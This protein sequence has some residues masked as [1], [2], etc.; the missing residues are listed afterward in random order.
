[1]SEGRVSGVNCI[2]WTPT[3]SDR[4]ERRRERRLPDARDVLDQE[5]A[6]GEEA[7]D[8][9]LHGRGRPAVGRPDG[10]DEAGDGARGRRGRVAGT[11]LTASVRRDGPSSTLPPK[12]VGG[13]RAA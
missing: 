7:D 11:A 6:P 12:R 8:R 3:P 13:V 4:A 2:R 1:M 5:V 9:V 10:G